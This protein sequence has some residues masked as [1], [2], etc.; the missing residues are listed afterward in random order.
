MSDHA[1]IQA[2]LSLSAA[3]LLD[4]AQERQVRTHAQECAACAADLDVY[5]A[6]AGG[7]RTLPAPQTPPWL[8]A[9]TA[10]LLAAET[11]RRH[12]A[13]L[14][15]ACSVFALAFVLL[16]A[17]TL[18]VLVGANA[19]IG[20]LLWGGITSVGGAV[21]ALVLNSQRRLERNSL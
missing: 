18:Y 1:A 16:A 11:D 14:A 7:L 10:A 3:G 15:A 21:S 20:W 19:A 5:G 8:V 6:L 4:A 9:R 2:L 12:G 13:R 17:I